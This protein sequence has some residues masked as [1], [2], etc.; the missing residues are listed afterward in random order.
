MSEVDFV[1]KY[2]G[3]SMKWSSSNSGGT[4]K[5]YKSGKIEITAGKAKDTGP[6]SWSGTKL[7]TKYKNFAKGKK[8]CFGMTA[9]KNGFKT[10]TGVKATY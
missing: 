9:I 2:V 3:K 7:C 6:W 10:S 1:N 5:Y 8:N 4:L